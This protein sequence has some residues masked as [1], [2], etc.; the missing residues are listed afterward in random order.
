VAL[1]CGQGQ[2]VDEG[3]GGL[4]ARTHEKSA[5]GAAPGDEV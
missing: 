4:R 1:V 3:I 2:A 5:F